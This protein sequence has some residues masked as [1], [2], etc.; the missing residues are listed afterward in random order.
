MPDYYEFW[1]NTMVVHII[2]GDKTQC[3]YPIRG[4]RYGGTISDI[5]GRKVCGQCVL[6]I[7]RE[8]RPTH[9]Q[10]RAQV[11]AAIRQQTED[12]AV[13]VGYRVESEKTNLSGLVG[14]YNQEGEL[15]VKIHGWK[16]MYQVLGVI[17]RERGIPV[18]PLPELENEQ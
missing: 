10:K 9:Q 13:Q 1:R 6:R 16:T 3:G 11:A 15:T 5:T 18:P 14:L 2:Q 8:G 17:A 4:P 12:L 7:E